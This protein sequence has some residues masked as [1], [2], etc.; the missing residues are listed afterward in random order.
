MR[1]VPIFTP[2]LTFSRLLWSQVHS[3]KLGQLGQ[4]FRVRVRLQPLS[5][6]LPLISLAFCSL[7]YMTFPSLSCM[8]T[9]NWSFN[10]YVY[11][12][13][14]DYC[15]GLRGA[16]VCWHHSGAD[17]HL[18]WERWHHFF[19]VLHAPCY[20]RSWTPAT[21]GEY[22]FRVLD[23]NEKYALFPVLIDDICSSWSPLI[24]LLSPQFFRKLWL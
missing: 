6:L 17:V 9:L 3:Q 4:S 12:V 16:R 8:F 1:V 10:V 23:E 5:H 22:A 15:S 13:W 7:Y 21:N 19:Q 20:S 14:K 11:L 18:P 24:L 2:C